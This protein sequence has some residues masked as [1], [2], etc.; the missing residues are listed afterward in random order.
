MAEIV[1]PVLLVGCLM[2][3]V[4]VAGELEGFLAPPPPQRAIECNGRYKNREPTREELDTVLR[5]HQEWLKTETK[6]NEEQRANLCQAVLIEADLREVKLQGADLRGAHL[7]GPICM[8]P[9]S[10]RP[11]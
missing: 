2:A 3:A 8:R 10:R 5:H 7:Q 9:T 1:M 6:P 11:I 4:V